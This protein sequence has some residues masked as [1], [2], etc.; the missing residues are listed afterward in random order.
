[1]SIRFQGKEGK[2]LPK[3]EIIANLISFQFGTWIAAVFALIKSES[4]IIFWLTFLLVA[5]LN[6]VVV[7][8][9]FWRVHYLA[10]S[11][12]KKQLEKI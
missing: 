10:S 8:F 4:G 6:G 1:M 7:V 9:I 3:D 11:S 12:R 2:I 5:V